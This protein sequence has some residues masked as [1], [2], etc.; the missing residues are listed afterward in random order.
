MARPSLQQIRYSPRL[1]FVD[2]IAV[3][4]VVSLDIVATLARVPAFSAAVSA[5]RCLLPLGCCGLFC[6]PAVHH[7]V[8]PIDEEPLLDYLRV[9]AY[10]SELPAADPRRIA[11][12]ARAAKQRFPAV[13]RFYDVSSGPQRSGDAASRLA[14]I[15]S[16]AA[17]HEFRAAAFPAVKKHDED[18]YAAYLEWPPEWQAGV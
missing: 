12:D 3:E 16:F 4:T 14:E 11:L 18:E 7:L 8:A 1:D 15:G 5:Y 10:C 6:R 2:F 9:A 17:R 13:F